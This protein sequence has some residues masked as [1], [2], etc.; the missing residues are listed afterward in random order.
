[1]K[2]IAFFL[3]P[4]NEV[5]F[6]YDDFTLEESLQKMRL[7]G[8]TYIPVINRKCKYVGTMSEGDFLWYITDNNIRKDEYNDITVKE[9]DNKEKIQPVRI[10]VGIDEILEKSMNQNFIPVIDDMGTFIGIVT[11]KEII[12][13]LQNKED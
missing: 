3:T 9:I 12:G 11:R 4:K 1:M 13:Y 10:T 8:Y 7:Y 5:A 6:L 2:N